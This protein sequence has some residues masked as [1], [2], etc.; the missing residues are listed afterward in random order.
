MAMAFEKM[1]VDGGLS[2]IAI[3]E[4]DLNVRRSASASRKSSS[5]NFMA[6]PAPGRGQPP[7]RDF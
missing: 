1:Q 6:H 7:T 4:Q 2:Q 3:A 5:Q